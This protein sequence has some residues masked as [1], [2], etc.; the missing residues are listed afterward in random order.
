MRKLKTAMMIHDLQAAAPLLGLLLLAAAPPLG[1]QTA[2]LV[3]DIET[4][5]SGVQGPG[6]FVQ[7]FSTG[8]RVF[9][10]AEEASV[11][12]ELWVT[13]G[14]GAGTELLVDACAGTCSSAAQPLGAAGQVAF[15]LI[16]PDPEQFSQPNLLW[17]S[18]GTRRGT[19]ALTGSAL[20]VGDPLAYAVAGR[21]LYFAACDIPG[22]CGLARS[23]GSPA[24]TTLVA[25]TT[26]PTPPLERVIGVAVV[27]KTIFFNTDS[28][29]WTTEGTADSTHLVRAFASPNP[30]VRLLTAAA[31]RVYFLA[32]A[33]SPQLW[34]SDGTAAG[35]VQLT[36]YQAP[37]PFRQT[38]GFK[39]AGD[40][41]YFVA[42]D[43]VHGA[44]I[45]ASD[46]TAG[47]TRAV[48]DFGY[49]DPFDFSL[50]EDP[51]SPSRMELLGQR[52]IF[53]ATDGLSPTQLWKTDGT[54]PSTAPISGVGAFSP[55]VRVGARIV[56]FARTNRFDE[57]WSTD[58][59]AAGTVRL[60]TQVEGVPLARLGGVV[61][62]TSNALWFTD[63]TTA[64]TRRLNDVPLDLAITDEG[65]LV[66]LGDKLFF[67]SSGSEGGTS[68][69]WLT[70]GRKGG[71]HPILGSQ[72]GTQGSYPSHFAALGSSVVFRTSP[73]NRG[74]GSVWRSAGD[75]ATTSAV[76]DL[77][78]EVGPGPTVAGGRAYFWSS[79]DEGDHF[80]LWS[81]DGTSAATVLGTFGLDLVVPPDL[82][83]LGARIY[84]VLAPRSGPA[85]VWS[86][87]G[88]P[89]GTAKVFDLP[90]APSFGGGLTSVGA[91]LYFLMW[92]QGE[93]E[94][95]TSDGTAAGT[96]QVSTH[97]VSGAIDFFGS[98]QFTPVGPLVFFAGEHD[99]WV[100]DGTSTGTMLV[101]PFVNGV[102][103][104]SLTS[105]RGALYF[106]AANGAELWRSDGTSVGT[107]RIATI[108]P[109]TNLRPIPP[110]TGT[111]VVAADRLF[112]LVDDGVHG[113]EPWTSDGTAAG[114]FLL[115]DVN[116]GPDSSSPTELA[117]AGGR[118]FFSADDGVHGNELWVSDG[119]PEGT[120]LAADV[121]PEALSSNPS[122]L[123]VAGERL[124]F[125][126][127]D[128]LHGQELWALPLSGPSGCQTTATAL[129]L[130]G[131]R[132][133]VEAEWRD[134]QGNIGQ[135]EALPL[136][137]DT[138]AFWFF[139]ASNLEVVIKVVDGR[140]LNQ[141]FWVFYGALSSVDYTLTV[142]DTQTGLSRRYSNPAGQLASVADTN[143]FGPLGA[144][145]TPPPP[146]PSERAAAALVSSRTERAAAGCAPSAAQLCL[147]AGRFAVKASWKD[148]QGHTG[149][150]TAV[151]LT[152]DTGYFWFFNQAN[153]EVIAKLLDGRGLNGKFWFFYGALSSVEYTLTVTDTVTGAVKT[154][155]NPSGTLASVADTGAF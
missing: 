126:A 55:L 104:S 149:K 41:V 129:C 103:V 70:D 131:G 1:A 113:L 128:G 36:N 77:I 40:A 76:T 153:V 89:Q 83:P 115:R 90:D 42:D 63:G 39:V 95:W 33:A 37:Q 141:A 148:F 16:G 52:L 150:G 74:V 92:R 132:F 57:V 59:T 127:D 79:I 67:D 80:Q 18:D 118:V 38:A 120:R 84:S 116:P 69:P 17:S 47:G 114:T 86:S 22:P 5:T 71:T 78:G 28:A 102:E 11:G 125:A 99:V 122:G 56:F 50:G 15:F 62:S 134:F 66:Q 112:L 2:Y 48:T 31:H 124:Y 23:D 25:A 60:E 34:T 44:E 20:A 101:Y 45:W 145:G 146:A 88:T 121:A 4:S 10:S 98:P 135:G 64:G 93:F 61:F 73:M 110:R 137:G 65:R 136:T 107:A 155:T 123:T 46:G 6:G 117:A 13:D 109:G 72:T 143:A 81:V 24:G 9:F 54:P 30:A 87:D 105:F 140:G 8:K 151:Q 85:E 133:R 32:N 43:V 53:P 75:A 144:F 58:G 111:M 19:R 29:L 12:S 82:V 21:F 97:Q 49:Y 94:V 27:G 96:H 68:S 51:L 138:G 130:A 119:T 3:R 147:S 35:T 91:S 139:S 106:L 100:T 108:G 142:T 14:T 154:Y 7:A 152:A 26:S